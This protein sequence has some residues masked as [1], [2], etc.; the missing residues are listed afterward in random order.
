MHVCVVVRVELMLLLS[1]C[2]RGTRHAWV[3]VCAELLLLSNYCCSENMHV[4]VAV[5]RNCCCRGGSV[6]LE[7]SMR[8]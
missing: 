2:R 4:C 6:C 7:L 1:Y 3:A 8:V 5:G